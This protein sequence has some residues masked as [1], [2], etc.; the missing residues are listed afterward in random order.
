MYVCFVCVRTC[1]C[2]LFVICCVMLYGMVVSIVCYAGVCLCVFVVL[3]G[4]VL[5]ERYCV[6]LV[7][8]LLCDLVWFMFGVFLCLWVAVC[9]RLVNVFVCCV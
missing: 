1:L 9:V 8:K 3:S 6:C 2:V 5:F 7:C 4:C